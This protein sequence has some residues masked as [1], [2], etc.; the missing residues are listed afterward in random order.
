[1]S[2]N[3]V[4]SNYDKRQMFRVLKEIELDNELIE[5]LFYQL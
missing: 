4:F 2:V 5:F 3:L 1:M